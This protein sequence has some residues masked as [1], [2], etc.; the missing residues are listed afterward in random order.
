[1]MV[2]YIRLLMIM[3]RES[4]GNHD[5][6]SQAVFSARLTSNFGWLSQKFHGLM[7]LNL[8]DLGPDAGAASAAAGYVSAD[9]SCEAIEIQVLVP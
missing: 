7:D 3:T 2:V 5:V 6:W 9:A 1:M 8:T 4:I